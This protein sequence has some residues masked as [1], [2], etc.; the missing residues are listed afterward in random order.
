MPKTD[1]VAKIEP[2]ALLK[3]EP[4]TAAAVAR[5]NK[6]ASGLLATAEKLT[7]NDADDYTTAAELRKIVRSVERDAE[8]TEKA[9]VAP[10]NAVVKWIRNMLDG[11]RATLKTA[12]QTVDRKMLNWQVAEEQKRIN[13]ERRLRELQAASQPPTPDGVTR[14]DAPA[15]VVVP[16]SIP[17]VEGVKLVTRWTFRV[18]DAALIPREFLVPDEKAL[19][20]IATAQHERASVAG[21]EFYSEQSVSSGRR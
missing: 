3:F 18:V 20:A 11:P 15:P 2:E 12:T 7:V 5:L 9:S 8:D 13:E 19:Q 17:K 4:N 21:V 6:Q 1:A 14:V 16:T 10:F